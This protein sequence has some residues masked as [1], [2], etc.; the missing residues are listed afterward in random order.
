VNAKASVTARDGT[1]PDRAGSRRRVRVTG[2]D[3]DRMTDRLFLDGRRGQSA[4]WVLLTLAG[5]IASTGVVGDSVATVIGAM[6]VAPLMTPILGTA[7]A[8]V[9]ADRARIVRG[10]ALIVAGSALVVTIGYLTGL[11]DP[12][13]VLADTNSQVAARVSPH[14]VDLLGAL[15][16]G[17]VGAFAL[18]RSDISDTLPGVAIAG[19]ARSR[20]S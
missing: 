4:F 2:V 12:E 14:V 1:E 10:I 5:V 16:T 8:V 6:I 9:L 17:L 11:L 15:A 3:V 20:S 19:P 18:V 7:P 13:P